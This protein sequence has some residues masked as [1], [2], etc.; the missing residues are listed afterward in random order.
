MIGVANLRQDRSR[1]RVW[2]RE[3]VL[4]RGHRGHAVILDW[5]LVAVGAAV[6]PI[7]VKVY[8]LHIDAVLAEGM[9]VNFSFSAPIDE[10]D[11]E[12]EGGVRRL[13]ELVFSN[14]EH[15]IE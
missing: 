5:V 11:A 7:L 12:F 8:A 1:V 6:Q 14:A 10:L 4:L 3:L 13:H 9:D 2:Q 15:L